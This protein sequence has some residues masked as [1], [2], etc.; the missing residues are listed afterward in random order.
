MKRNTKRRGPGHGPMGA[1]MPAERARD[2]KG[3]LKRLS[4]YLKPHRVLLIVVALLSIAGVVLTIAGPKILGRATNIL[5]EGVIGKQLPP[6]LGKE[7]IIAMLK[8]A[9]RDQMAEMVAGM[10]IVPGA[11]VD[12]AAIARVLITLVVIYI[13]IL[14]QLAA[15]LHHGGH[16][17]ANVRPAQRGRREACEATSEILRQ[18]HAERS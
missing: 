8:A 17:P 7:Q 11:G 13:G 6:G 12:F 4:G 5:F 2:F 16:L 1:M 14:L 9:G 15:A 10:N 3:S 18:Q